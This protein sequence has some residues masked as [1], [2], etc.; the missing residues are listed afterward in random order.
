[1]YPIWIEIR[2]NI[3]LLLKTLLKKHHLKLFLEYNGRRL[4]DKVLV[5]KSPKVSEVLSRKHWK[6]ATFSFNKLPTNLWVFSP[7]KTYSL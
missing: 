5:F 7:T 2:E 3:T 6:Q 4:R 1:M